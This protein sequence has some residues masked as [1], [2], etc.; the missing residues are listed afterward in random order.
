MTQYIRAVIH[1]CEQIEENNELFLRDYSLTLGIS[2]WI[3]QDIWEA[4]SRLPVN[5]WGDLLRTYC[6]I[7]IEICMRPMRNLAMQDYLKLFILNIDMIV[8]LSLLMFVLN[9]VNKIYRH[10]HTMITFC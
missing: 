1:A 4:V 8:V 9:A 2:F 5:S 10:I 7:L 6:L 3:Y